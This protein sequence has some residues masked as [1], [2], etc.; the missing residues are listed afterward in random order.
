MTASDYAQQEVS[1]DG[2]HGRPSPLGAGGVTQ[3][4]R[5]MRAERMRLA[6]MRGSFAV[7]AVALG[8]TLLWVLPWI[9][10]GLTTENYSGPAGGAVILCVL[11]FAG[12]LGFALV[13]APSFRN[14]PLPEFLRVLFGG[15]QLIRGRHQFYSRLAAECRRARRDRRYLFSIVIIQRGPAYEQHD[16]LEP[17]REQD[18]AAM[19]L[20]GVV[21]TDDV[22]ATSPGALYV[23]IAGA[24]YEA[25]ERVCGRIAQALADFDE[26]LGLTGARAIGSATYGEDGD[27]PELLLFAMKQRMRPMAAP[28]GNGERPVSAAVAAHEART[29]ARAWPV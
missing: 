6:A 14:E 16:W 15:H 28:N 2:D 18:V 3:V 5:Q 27:S 10:L 20:R 12:A 11:S 13:W 1:Q 7:L 4:V 17:S 19:L 21:R 26:P 24:G 23:L 25:R 22:V 8:L 9:P 29:G